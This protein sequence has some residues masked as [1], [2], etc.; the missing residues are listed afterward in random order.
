VY[1]RA[2][3]GGSRVTDVILQVRFSTPSGVN[4]NTFNFS[5]GA[6]VTYALHAADCIAQVQQFYENGAG[7]S[8]GG[9]TASYIGRGYELRAYNRADPKPRVPLVGFG[10]LPNPSFPLTAQHVPM[11]T[12]MCL[13]YHA[14]PPITRRRRGRIYLGGVVDEWM[15]EGG[16][17]SPPRFG[18]GTGS[19]AERVAIAANTLMT[20]QV[21]WS[22]W[23]SAG[24]TSSRI[25]GGYI[26]TEPDTQRRR[27]VSTSS[28]LL[29]P[30]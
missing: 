4:V 3:E 14:A 30:L 27:G 5:S 19:V 20:H 25:V 15:I 2:T 6:Y 10:A 26:D 7:N 8:I 18:T 13:S 21:G 29:W 12:A 24:A 16:A 22:I 9:H 28:R 23:S 1:Y 17:G 11:D